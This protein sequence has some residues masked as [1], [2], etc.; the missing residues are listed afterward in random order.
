MVKKVESYQ[1][2]SHG[3]Y[4]GGNPD[5][6]LTTVGS[7]SQFTDERANAIQAYKLFTLQGKTED[8]RRDFSGLSQAASRLL[9][10]W[11]FRS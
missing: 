3:V 2:N 8:Y 6:W 10:W 5:V 11:S 1:W 4:L 7:L 9:T